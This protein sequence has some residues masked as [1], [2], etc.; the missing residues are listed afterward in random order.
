MILDTTFVQGKTHRWGVAWSYD[1]SLM[2]TR[3]QLPQKRK[4]EPFIVSLPKSYSQESDGY[5]RAVKWMEET[6]NKLKVHIVL[7]S[8]VSLSLLD[9]AC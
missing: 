1:H 5:Q 9:R 4:S 2:L 6:L 3:E 7:Y 8:N